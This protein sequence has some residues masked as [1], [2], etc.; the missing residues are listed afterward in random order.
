MKYKKTYFFRY[1][2]S[3]VLR[4]MLITK[5]EDILASYEQRL[6]ASSEWIPDIDM[7]ADV[8]R[9]IPLPYGADYTGNIF[10]LEYQISVSRTV[11]T[12][13]EL[14]AMRQILECT[15][16]LLKASFESKDLESYG[17]HQC[18]G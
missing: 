18:N 2:I 9:G 13:E 7:S 3:I 16:T 6:K 4:D 12:L 8:I 5:A 11:H 1:E 17:H 15:A 10:Q 14:W